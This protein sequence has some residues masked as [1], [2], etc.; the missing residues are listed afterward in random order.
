[1]IAGLIA[2]K[3]KSMHEAAMLKNPSLSA[4]QPIGV[5]IQETPTNSITFRFH[6]DGSA[7]VWLLNQIS[8][9]T[10]WWEHAEPNLR[11]LKLTSKN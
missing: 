7:P 9:T 8:G 10:G 5:H 6:Q 1:M 3:L 11:E 2:L 4:V